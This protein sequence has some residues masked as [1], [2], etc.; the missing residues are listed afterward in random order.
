MENNPTSTEDLKTIRKIMEESTRFLS[1]SGLSGV[2]IGLIAIAGAV[3]A[4]LTITY[5]WNTDYYKGIKIS[6]EYQT[7]QNLMLGID[8][9]MVLLLSIGVALYFSFRKASHSGKSFW[10]PVSRRMFFNLTIPMVTGGIFS[11]VL[12]FQHQVNQI[13]PVFLIFYGIALINA[14]KFTYNETLYLGIL[15][16]LTG[17]VSAIFQTYG[18]IFWII[19]FGILHIGYGLFM[20]RKYEA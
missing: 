16:I 8:A 1:I 10:T 5:S 12:L 7:I 4:Y 14:W 11:L 2:F 20:Y 15:E 19:G 13:I 17:L 9:V 6:A 3:V 18:L